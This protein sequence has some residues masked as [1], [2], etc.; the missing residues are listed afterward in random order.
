MSRLAEP[1]EPPRETLRG[2]LYRCE[3]CGYDRRFYLSPPIGEQRRC[4]KCR[5]YSLEPVR[6]ERVLRRE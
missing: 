1:P 3:R 2:R 5:R 4:P 6:D